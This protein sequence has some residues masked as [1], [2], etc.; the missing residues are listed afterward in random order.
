MATHIGASF[1]SEIL[2]KCSLR[3][4]SLSGN[5][6]GDDGIDVI[7]RVLGNSQ[8]CELYIKKCGIT[9]I[10][11]KS[12]ATGLIINKT[13]KTI[14]IISNPITV[15]GAC[16]ILQSAVDNGVCYLVD[17][18]YRSNE[19]TKRIMLELEMRRQVRI[20]L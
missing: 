15:D 2:W 7:A 10:G 19:K 20:T 13:I 1:I 11:A 3:V 12:L 4:L 6:I 16:L 14:A 17:A 8:I 5:N 9:L 18:E